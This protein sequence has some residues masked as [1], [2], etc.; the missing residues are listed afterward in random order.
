MTVWF[1][2]PSNRLTAFENAYLGQHV[3]GADAPDEDEVV[4]TM[5]AGINAA[6]DPVLMTGSFRVE[7]DQVSA[8]KIGHAPWLLTYDEFP[9]EADWKPIPEPEE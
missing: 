4:G 7:D 1:V 8:L 9:P 5:V 6:G 3:R 2:I